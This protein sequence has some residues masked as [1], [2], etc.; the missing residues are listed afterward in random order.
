MRFMIMVPATPATGAGNQASEIQHADMAAYHQQLAKAGVLLDAAA[1]YTL[2]E[3]KTREEAFEWARRWPNRAA[4]RGAAEIE[5]REL[6]A[7]DPR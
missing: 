2:I 1:G 3:T 5:V 4:E 6:P 7:G